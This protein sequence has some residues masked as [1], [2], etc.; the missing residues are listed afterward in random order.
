MSEETIEDKVEDIV[1]AVTD[2]EKVNQLYAMV[3]KIAE[4]VNLLKKAKPIK[5]IFDENDL[6]EKD[7]DVNKDGVLDEN[8]KALYRAY[9]KSNL[10]IIDYAEKSVERHSRNSLWSNVILGSIFLLQLILSFVN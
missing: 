7:F 2:K 1:E 5:E 8:E 6:D 4:D 10:R 3:T 9:E